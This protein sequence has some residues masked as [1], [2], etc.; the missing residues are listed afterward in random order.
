MPDRKM[1][2]DAPD[3]LL[4]VGWT[5]NVRNM[6]ESL[7]IIFDPGTEVRGPRLGF[8]RGVILAFLV[9]ILDCVCVASFPRPLDLS[10]TLVA[11]GAPP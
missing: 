1:E 7:N 9:L 10:L 5:E 8:L 11:L 4:F 6:L 2:A 3:R